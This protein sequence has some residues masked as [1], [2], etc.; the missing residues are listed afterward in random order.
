M[1]SLGEKLK[2][3]RE[4]KKISLEQAAKDT[5]IS[6]RYLKG[7]EDEDFSSFPGEAYVNGFLRN[8]GTYL[9]LN[10][11]ELLS[12]YRSLKLQEQPVPVEQLLKKPSS[13]TKIAFALILGIIAAGIIGGG[14]YL[15][16]AQI[17][18]TETVINVP[19]QPSKYEMKGDTFDRHFFIDDS[20][21]IFSE[22]KSILLTL[23]GIGDHITLGTLDGEKQFDAINGT[24]I[25][26]D[27][28]G[29]Y[30]IIN[31]FPFE[32]DRPE[33]GVRLYIEKKLEIINLEPDDF[34]DDAAVSQGQFI[35]PEIFPVSSTP[36]PFTLQ[37]VFQ[38]YCM[39]RWEI[40][41]ERERRERREQFFQRSE[42]I[43]IQAQNGI[44]LWVSNA[45]A[46][47]FMVI[48][49]GRTAP[50]EIGGAGEVVVCEIKWVRGADNRW[51]LAAARMET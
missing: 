39:F 17:N 4:A 24:D 14:I 43:N 16:L 7:L 9:D 44:R 13:P 50:I 42:E 25:P 27:N 12:L 20:I 36:Y 37:S 11:Q 49:A 28:N 18:S 40:L 22:T 29:L 38:N 1:E 32:K 2:T 46:V 47:K 8:Y 6:M 48:G 3:V 34:S 23:I 26:I 35:V 19:R 30:V 45:Q 31:A 41:F 15:I 10:I 33:N 5:K 21:E 51:R